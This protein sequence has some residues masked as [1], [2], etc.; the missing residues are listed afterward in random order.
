MPIGTLMIDSNICP[1]QLNLSSHPLHPDQQSFI[2]TTMGYLTSPSTDSYFTPKTI[3]SYS[4]ITHTYCVLIIPQNFY[5]VL[6]ISKLVRD[7][8]RKCFLNFET[9]QQLTLLKIRVTNLRQLLSTQILYNYFHFPK[10]YQVPSKTYCGLLTHVPASPNQIGGGKDKHQGHPK[11]TDLTD[12]PARRISRFDNVIYPQQVEEQGILLLAA[13]L[14]IKQQWAPS[15][16]LPIGRSNDP[17]DLSLT[18]AHF[19]KLKM[20]TQQEPNDVLLYLADIRAQNVTTRCLR[21][22]L[23]HGAMTGDSVLN[24]FLAILCEAHHLSFLSTFFITLLRRDRTWSS[25]SEWFATEVTS[26]K[27]FRPRSNSNIPIL[28]PCHVNNAHWVALVR[29]TIN[30][31][32]HFLFAD[33]LNLPTTEQN[34]KNLLQQLAPPDFY[35]NNAI[36]LHCNSSTYYPHSNECG[37]RTLFALMVMA[38][39]PRPNSN[40]LLP[41]MS[42]NLAQILRTWIGTT[43]LTGQVILPPWLDGNE[44]LETHHS[45]RK[46]GRPCYLF[47]WTTTP[48]TPINGTTPN[49]SRKGQYTAY[50]ANSLTEHPLISQTTSKP[51]QEGIMEILSYVRDSVRSQTP[52]G[53][54]LQKSDRPAKR[55]VVKNRTQLTIYDALKISPPMATN[56]SNEVWG[57]FPEKIEEKSTLR[58]VFA[59]PRGLKLTYD[60]FETEY[61]MGRCQSLGVGAMCL[62]ESNL[63]WSHPTANGKFHEALRKI[64]HHS[65]V[66]KSHTKDSFSTMNQPGGTVTTV[67]NHWTSRVIESGEDPFGLGRWSYQV[68]RGKGGITLLI[69]TAYR[70][71]RQSVHSAGFTTST[72]QQH[73]ILSS[74]FREA[75]RVDDPIPRH[76][77]I[78]DLQSWLEHKTTQGYLIVLGIDANEP[79]DS[80]AGNFT[81]LEFQLEK[82]IPTHGH[83]GTLS[84]L[85]RTSGL[86]DPLLLHHPDQPPPP[87]YDRGKEK[88]DF[89]FVSRGLLPCVIRSGIFPYNSIF[90]SDHRPCYID[91]DSHQLFQENTPVIAPPQHRGLRMQDP[92]L[93]T[94]YIDTLLE[95]VLYHKIPEKATKLLNAAEEGSW[96]P[97]QTLE[98]EKLDKLFTEAMTKAERSV[99]KKYSTTYQWSPSL[100][101]AIHTLSYWKLRLSQIKGK[102]ISH[103]SL[104][105]LFKHTKLDN[106]KRKHLPL[107]EVIQMIRMA[108]ADLKSIQKRHVELREQHL[109]NLVNALIILRAPSLLEPGREQ[110]YDKKK[111]REIRRIKRKEALTRL[112]RKIGYTLR[113]TDSRGGLSRVDIPHTTTRDPYPIGPDPKTWN[114]P[115][116]SINEPAEIGRQVC[117]ANARQY[118]QAHSTPCGT[119]PLASHLGYKADQDGSKSIIAGNPLPTSITDLLLPETKSIFATLSSL[120]QLDNPTLSPKITPEQFQSCYKAMDERTSSSPSGRHLGHYKA[121]TQSDALTKLH[122][123]MMSI[124]LTAGFSPTRWQ[125]VIDVMLEKKAGDHRIHRLRIVA[126]QESDFNQSNRLA[127]GRPLQRLVEQLNLAPDMQHGSRASKLCHSAVLNKQLTFEIHRYNKQPLAYIENDAVGCYDRI[128]NPLVLIFLRILGLSPSVVASLATTWE[129]T[130]HRVRTM[131]GI[132]EEV[133]SN[134]PNNLLY[135]PGQGSTIGPFLWLLCFILI[136]LSLGP[137]IPNIKLQAVDRTTSIDFVGEAFV[138]DAG[139]G[140]NT[141]NKPPQELVK[142]LQVVAQRWEKLLFST[143]GALNLS[144][145]FWFLLAWRWENGKPT[146]HT[147]ATAPGILQMTSENESTPITVPR[148]EPTSSFRTLG[149]HISPSGTNTGALKV[150]ENIVLDYCSL[151]RGS[152]FTRQEALTSYI[153]YL[154]PKVR[155]QPPLLS[156]NQQ[157]CDKLMSKILM[158]LLPKLH[159]NRNTARSIVFGVEKYG[160][161]GLPNL[162]IVQGVDKLKLFLGHLRIQDRTGNLIHIDMSYIQLLTGSGTL[163]LNQPADSYLWIDSGWLQSLWKFTS[164]YSLGFLYP[165]GWLPSKPRHHDAFLME[166]F[167]LHNP[168]LSEMRTLNRCRIFL[169]VITLSDIS[170]ADGQR[171]VSDAK[172]GERL[173]DRASKLLWPTQ[174]K[175]T[176]AD[177][178]VWR[179]H[180]AYFEN[181]GKLI[182][183]LGD[184]VCSSHQRWQYTVDTAT[185]NV[186]NSFT[187]PP[188]MFKPIVH[189]RPLRSG[190]CYNKRGGRPCNEVPN[191][192]NPVTMINNP[193]TDG[194]LFRILLSPN[195]P[196]IPNNPLLA[197]KDRRFY[198]LLLP[199]HQTIPYSSLLT[200][201]QLHICVTGGVDRVQLTTTS[202]W[203]FFSETV[204]FSGGHTIK[205]VCSTYRTILRGILTVL[206]IVYRAEQDYPQETFPTII[207]QSS[208]SKALKEAFRT[209]PVGVTTANQAENDFILEIRFLRSRLKSHVHSCCGQ[210]AVTNQ[211]HPVEDPIL[212]LSYFRSP[213]TETLQEAVDQSPLSHVVSVYHN[214]MT[215]TGD[216]RAYIS[217]LAYSSP[218]QAKLRKDN[219]WDLTQFQLIDWEAYHAAQRHIPRAHRISIVKLSNQLWNVNQQNNKYYGES[220]AC[221]ICSHPIET[222]AHVF[223]CHHPEA[224]DNRNA[225]FSSFVEILKKG[226]PEILLE[227]V[228]SGMHQWW[229]TNCT[230]TIKPPTT[231][232]RLPSFQI[233]HQAF[234][235][236]TSIGWDAFHRGHVTHKWKEAFKQHLRPRTPISPSRL[237]LAAGKWIRLMITTVWTYSSKLWNFRNQ[238]VH[239]KTELSRISKT[240]RA[241][242]DKTRELYLR[243]ENDP[244]MVPESSRYLFTR[245]VEN[246]LL[247]HPDGLAAWIRSVEEGLLTQ[248]HREQLS[249]AHLRQTLHHFLRPLQRVG[250]RR[251]RKSIWDAPFSRAY[252]ASHKV[253]R[254][255]SRRI[256]KQGVKRI[257]GGQS[258]LRPRQ[259][260]L[261][262]HGTQTRIPTLLK[263]GFTVTKPNRRS[264][265]P[266]RDNEYSGTR[267]ST[268]P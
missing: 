234:E 87:T 262:H 23:S 19:E 241:L 124:P 219:D 156:L 204:S 161:L 217:D 48:A 100:K 79:Y 186:F 211:H 37:P 63:N 31:Q 104:Q 91:I 27:Y 255:P 70:V 168:S 267:V 65:K 111:Q 125:Q 153:Q 108:R 210:T 159:V 39:H 1:L 222:T 33:D 175:P 149:V 59:N 195:A 103:H 117:A 52:N 60:I 57:H 191:G 240:L 66:A 40:I 12:L 113:P 225:A 187:S 121:A 130:Y 229:H 119:E 14:T 29:R 220:A 214:K 232:S 28:I 242:Q 83:D 137:G 250:H 252:Y 58:L 54:Q 24:T 43:L 2:R 68:L 109:E 32:V 140:V 179:R 53:T 237:E 69:V 231:G 181:K 139:L 49:T 198:D 107:E 35:P 6:L 61:S 142:D 172:R 56:D 44:G 118:H 236:Q 46:I 160:G 134:H 258:K 180:L 78:V 166:E 226:T 95:Q 233:I 86:A 151:V 199:P 9:S 55:P 261:R 16:I 169:Q 247:M 239:G 200:T 165:N 230:S 99:S 120:A 132:S 88:I 264:A 96:T 171:I 223:K 162:Y 228:I 238:V 246:M 138:D 193:T 188:M 177:W 77:F 30:N 8:K 253:N 174:G 26:E 13:G 80:S 126:L 248:E 11:I 257:T 182:R 21:E 196:P 148:I 157:D 259:S 15:S 185:G 71:C 209:T 17:L 184:W 122:S 129:A 135:G 18:D 213:S 20:A 76:Q 50:A 75:G 208:S 110:A 254:A 25:L 34:L 245:P 227:A 114:G 251:K 94:Q 51:K 190:N 178:A 116:Q 84:T 164:Q 206:Y 115:W 224:I 136:F 128:V 215:I 102:A 173:P 81:P 147:A 106:E 42:H 97:D 5:Y 89:I 133:Y 131:Y 143:G 268:A 64:W 243:F 207:L 73:R 22:L 93:V 189:G 3:T 183:P 216:I 38:L 152:H 101:A 62:A 4:K 127:I 170:T 141:T 74:H 202:S 158:A 41:Y 155:F 82:P 176:K 235:A 265:N 201:E 266:M 146:L 123:C 85:V 218:L 244:F 192:L 67:L 72:A 10:L 36:W 112:H 7:Q 205:G 92:R 90:M 263:Y 212:S 197:P 249:A 45:T 145:C 47:Q 194:N 260:R 167:Q 256:F 203:E 144:K 163:F 154:L 221:P 105:K 150:L 98:F